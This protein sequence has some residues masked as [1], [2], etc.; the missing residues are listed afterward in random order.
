MAWFFATQSLGRRNHRPDG[1]HRASGEH[2]IPADESVHTPTG[3][4]HL[5]QLQAEIISRSG[6]RCNLRHPDDEPVH[7]L[8]I[9]AEDPGNWRMIWCEPSPISR[10]GCC[11]N[12]TECL[13]VGDNGSIAK[14]SRVPEAA[15]QI[16]ASLVARS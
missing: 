12:N 11:A 5:E 1:K 2:R 13:F 16:I 9:Q 6:L 8:I 15:T 14:A 10:G 3:Q 7:L 4:H